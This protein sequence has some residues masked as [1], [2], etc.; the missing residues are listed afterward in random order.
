MVEYQEI[1]EKVIYYSLQSQKTGLIKG[2][3][4][5][6]SLRSDDGKVIAITPTSI[7]YE[8]LKPEDI[9]LVDEYGKILY[10][11]KK[12]SS[13]LPMHTHVLRARKDVKTVVHTHAMFCTIMSVLNISLKPM[14]IPQLAMGLFPI[15]VVPFEI[16]GS[17]ELGNAIVKG[18]GEHG[19]AVLMANHGMLVVDSSL[20]KAFAGAEYL[21][22][23]AQI[24]YY[25][26]LGGGMNPIPEAFIQTMRKIA[27]TRAL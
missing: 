15:G 1:R 12:P 9:P 20:E 18:L 26:L 17:E 23:A 14:T 6:I 24:A 7:P 8:L 13:E 3:S 25:S 22:E 21:E 10:G 19:K 2:T 5:N 4:G 11:T 27:E 16:P